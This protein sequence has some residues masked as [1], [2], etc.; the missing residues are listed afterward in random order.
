MPQ[1]LFLGLVGGGFEACRSMPQ[2]TENWVGTFRGNNVGPKCQSH[3]CAVIRQRWTVLSWLN[4]APVIE[5]LWFHSWEWRSATPLAGAG[6]GAHGPTWFFPF[7]FF[8]LLCFDRSLFSSLCLLM[9]AVE[10]TEEGTTHPNSNQETTRS[11]TGCLQWASGESIGQYLC[12]TDTQG[13][14]QNWK[15]QL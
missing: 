2:H 6:A 4:G 9:S 13:E 14:G 5:R 8:A 12:C 7:F 3:P 10:P 1:H 11:T 15:L